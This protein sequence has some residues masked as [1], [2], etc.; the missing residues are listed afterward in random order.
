MGMT[1]NRCS[2]FI[3]LA[4]TNA[5]TKSNLGKK[6]I[7]LTIPDYSLLFLGNQVKN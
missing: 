3:Y 1:F 5:L 2:K 4:R 6:F 7:W